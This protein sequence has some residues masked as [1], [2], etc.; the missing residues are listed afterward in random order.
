MTEDYV[1]FL[2]SMWIELNNP[3]FCNDDCN[4]QWDNY[5][6]TWIEEGDTF[7]WY[8]VG[9]NNLQEGIDYKYS[10]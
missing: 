7:L 1:V 8:L 6:S 5:E 2:K 9:L 4:C 3:T 10:V